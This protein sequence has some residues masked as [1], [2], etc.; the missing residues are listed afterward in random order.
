MLKYITLKRH[1]GTYERRW[2]RRLMIV[3]NMPQELI[4][5]TYHAWKGVFTGAAFWWRQA[6]PI[7]GQ[8]YV[9]EGQAG[10]EH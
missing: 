3:A 4:R 6:D 1:V 8:G 2:V 9:H 7:P 5:A 10:E